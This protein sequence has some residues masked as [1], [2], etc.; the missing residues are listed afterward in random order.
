MKFNITERDAEICLRHGPRDR[1]RGSVRGSP[2]Q[3]AVFR[4][5]VDAADLVKYI[6]ACKSPALL[7]GLCA[8]TAE[9]EDHRDVLIRY[10]CRIQF[11]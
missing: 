11:T 1:E 4:I 6:I 2:H 8:V 7:L 5:R 10:P 9:R 3:D